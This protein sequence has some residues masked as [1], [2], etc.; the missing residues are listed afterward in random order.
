MLIRAK[1]PPRPALPGQPTRHGRLSIA[2]GGLIAN[3]D[4]GLELGENARLSRLRKAV[5]NEADAKQ[6]RRTPH[7]AAPSWLFGSRFVRQ[8]RP[9]TLEVARSWNS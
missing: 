2:S 6:S 9:P 1:R 7:G 3:L 5:T 4:P 8:T